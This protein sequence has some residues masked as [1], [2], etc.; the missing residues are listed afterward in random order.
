MRFQKLYN[1]LVAIRMFET[2]TIEG[3]NLTGRLLESGLY[4]SQVKRA[5]T[6]GVVVMTGPKCTLRPGL[7][8]VTPS[9]SQGERPIDEWREDD[10][11]YQLWNESNLKA[12]LETVDVPAEVAG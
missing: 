12:S 5:V 8:V 7:T 11:T 2:E 10:G 1:D 4:A 3:T 9:S 6:R